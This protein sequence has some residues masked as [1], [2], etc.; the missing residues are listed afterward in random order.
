MAD[1]AVLVIDAGTS[2]IRCHIFDASGREL[3]EE[4][5]TYPPS[6]AP[7]DLQLAREYDP[8][9]VLL[10]VLDL[11]RSAISGTGARIRSVAVTSM[12]QAVAFLDAELRCLYLGPN[13][14][15]R[16]IFEGSAIDED[17]RGQV[18]RTTGHLPS[19]FFAPAKLAWMKS[20]R[21]E[22][23][24]RI[25][26]AV[27]FPD[28]LILRLTGRLASE[29]T[30]AGE[31]GL[32][33]I[34]S[35]QWAV[36]LAAD[37]N[38]PLDSS[39]PLAAAGTTIGE[40]SEAVARR[41]GIPAG[42]PV[43]SAGSDTQCAA[44]GMGIFEPG[45]VAIVAGWSAPVQQVTDQPVLSGE[46][47]TWAGCHLIADRWVVEASAGDAGR[48]YSW[49][50]E[51][52][53]REFSELELDAA[54]VGVGAEGT[55]AMLGHP[56]LNMAAVGVRA[57]GIVFPVPITMNERGPGH[58]ARAGLEST[59]FS[60]R[61]NLERLRELTGVS[62]RSIGLGG[63]MARSALFGQI[64]ADVLGT[65]I[66]ALRG[67]SATARGAAVCAMGALGHKSDLAGNVP[68][69]EMTRI[70]PDRLATA[71]YREHYDRWL[72]VSSALASVRI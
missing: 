48:A 58:I 68:T 20:N 7:R 25:S 52:T 29:P 42:T 27:T 64:V 30:L 18:Y 14:D 24:A 17:H 56:Q 66:L 2:V 55:V 31:A 19:F 10:A 5:S 70:H 63:G 1:E 26:T 72:E 16:A 8:D 47:S 38:L 33:D 35:R 53:G 36:G 41:T 9:T 22:L 3:A 62:H 37:L 49:I 59:A 57:G 46:C 15:L 28:W 61:S 67:V 44:L 4:R 71:E 23:F 39:V 65:D 45:D 13:V 54:A 51:T 32:L 21:P 34:A 12:R 6:I 60:I 50:S 69:G 43:T 40:V 11:M